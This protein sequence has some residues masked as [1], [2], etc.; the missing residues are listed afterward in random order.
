VVGEAA[1]NDVEV[2]AIVGPS[3]GPPTKKPECL[4]QKGFGA[5]DTIRTCD[6]CLRSSVVLF[7][8][9]IDRHTFSIFFIA[10]MIV[11]D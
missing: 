5:P 7:T 9:V 11:L 6:P 1:E 2:P 8:L 3:D 4:Q 10:L